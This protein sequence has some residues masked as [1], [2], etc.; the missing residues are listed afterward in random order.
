MTARSPLV[1]T[2]TRLEDRIVPTINVLFDFRFDTA[3]FF[4]NHPDR[5]APIRAAAADI[6]ARFSDTLA[7]IPF[8]TTPGD[9]WRAKFQ[10]PSGVGQDEEVTNLL[11]PANTIVVFVGARELLGPLTL[12]SGS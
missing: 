11:V 12:E 8:P 9:F 5:I 1:L 3:G 7:T 10:R 2:A 4:N 6:G